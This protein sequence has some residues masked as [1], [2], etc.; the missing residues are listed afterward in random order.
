MLMDQAIEIARH[1][2]TTGDVPVGAIV[3][4][5]DGQIIGTGSYER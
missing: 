5:K 1:A 4:N 2:I 3:V